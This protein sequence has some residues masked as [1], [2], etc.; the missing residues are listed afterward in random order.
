MVL[1]QLDPIQQKQTC[2]NKPQQTVTQNKPKY[3]ARFRRLVWLPAWTVYSFGDGCTVNWM[4]I[5]K[6]SN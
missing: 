4:H 1:Q 2:I 3:K 6:A 5:Q